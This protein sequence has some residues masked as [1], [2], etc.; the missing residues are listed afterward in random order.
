[1]YPS[2][3]S[4]ASGKHEKQ[5]VDYLK[6]LHEVFEKQFPDYYLE[7][8][9]RYY[10]LAESWN[11][12]NV[13][14][15]LPPLLFQNQLLFI[16]APSLDKELIEKIINHKV[17]KY[18]DADLFIRLYNVSENGQ[19]PEI[20]TLNLHE[21]MA[22]M[23]AEIDDE[24]DE[25]ESL[26]E[27]QAITL[28]PKEPFRQW[29]SKAQLIEE[30]P[31]KNLGFTFLVDMEVELDEDWLKNSYLQYFELLLLTFISDKRK[32]PRKRSYQLFLSWFDYYFSQDVYDTAE[33]EDD[34]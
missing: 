34:W 6:Q 31:Q 33:D 30:L 16:D 28:V 8:Y 25:D 2:K 13:Q 20:D 9:Q 32:W 4:Q 27:R 3:G 17:E 1:M 23:E 10:L 11:L 26:H 15:F 14:D 24:W 21:Y 7:P 19:D 5:Y 12:A 18:P 29:V 22:L